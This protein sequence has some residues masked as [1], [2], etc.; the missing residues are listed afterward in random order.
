MGTLR[1]KA[2]HQLQASI[3]FIQTEAFNKKQKQDIQ[4]EDPRQ[5]QAVLFM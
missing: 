3:I 5:I 1:K 4:Y 2:L